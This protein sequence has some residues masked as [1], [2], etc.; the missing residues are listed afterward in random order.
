MIERVERYRPTLYAAFGEI[1]ITALILYTML[2][3]P[4]RNKQTSHTDRIEC[5]QFGL[6]KALDSTISLE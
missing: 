4:F 3:I 2:Q 6:S 1:A 5:V